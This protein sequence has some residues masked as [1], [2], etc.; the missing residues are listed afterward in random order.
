[1]PV[2][3]GFS[4]KLGAGKDYVASVLLP[5]I[6]GD[7]YEVRTMAFADQLKWECAARNPKMTYEAMFMNKTAESRRALQQYGTENGR[8]VHGP[9]MWLRA[10]ECRILTEASRQINKAKRLVIAI[11]DARFP[12][13]VDFVL[14][15]LNGRVIRVIAPDRTTARANSECLSADALAHPSETSLD[16]YDF[17]T[18]VLDNSCENAANV[19]RD[20]RKILSR[21]LDFGN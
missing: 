7:A 6:L 3:I 5:K 20:L 21:C 8:N 13:E 1:M 19:E 18:D 14:G 2:V 15:K 12:N 11:T 16:T 9:D 10:L 4:G 17:G